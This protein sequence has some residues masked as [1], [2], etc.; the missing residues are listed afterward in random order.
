MK[1]HLIVDGGDLDAVLE[2]P[3]RP[4]LGAVQQP[5]QV[6]GGEADE[7][8]VLVAAVVGEAA[9]VHVAQFRRPPQARERRHGRR[10]RRRLGLAD[11]A[12]E[13][14]HRPVHARRT[15]GRLRPHLRGRLA[16]GHTVADA[17]RRDF[18]PNFARN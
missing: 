8:A 14:A 5:R 11:E 10:R 13:A 2:A 3:V 4:P 9:L 18:V 1:N 7:R 15:L 12:L 16:S 17:R 6:L